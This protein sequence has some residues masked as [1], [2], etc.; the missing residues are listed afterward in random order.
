MKRNTLA[1]F[2]LAQR[3]PEATRGWFKW[4]IGLALAGT[5]FLPRLPG[6]AKSSTFAPMLRSLLYTVPREHRQRVASSW[7]EKKSWSALVVVVATHTD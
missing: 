4:L 6:A 1:L 2:A 7:I 3:A 5:A